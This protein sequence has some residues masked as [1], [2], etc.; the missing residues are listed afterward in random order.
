MAVGPVTRCFEWVERRLEEGKWFRRL[1]VVA[2]SGLMWQVT[3]WAM[4]Y[5]EANASRSGVDIA[6]VIGA[7]SAVPGAI[8]AF[9]FKQY[10]ESR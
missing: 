2:A 9:A 5:A 6:A 3:I 1:Y 7:V 10:M 8:V 4:R